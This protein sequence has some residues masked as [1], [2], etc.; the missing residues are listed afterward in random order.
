[1]TTA[2][3]MNLIDG[4]E[5]DT[6]D[7]RDRG[8]MYGDGVFRTCAMRGARIPHWGRQYS[9]LAADCDAINIVCPPAQA[10]ESDIALIA[11]RDADCVV[12]ITV[13][14]GAGA[15][16]YAIPT[17][18][19]PRRIVSTS[20]L[21]VYP[22][23]SY[24]HGV[25]LHLC[26][27]RLA[28][29]PKLAGIKHL[30]RLEQVLARSEWTDSASPE[31]LMRDARGNVICGTMSNLFIIEGNALLT[32]ALDECGVAGVQ[33]DR[34][35]DLARERGI[36]CR[37]AALDLQ[38]VLAADGVFL[39]NSVIGLWPVAQIARERCKQAALTSHIQEWLKA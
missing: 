25:R 11:A 16:G 31:G 5:A 20:A 28:L 7:V 3:P 14:R 1:M 33:R 13:T 36:D 21:P 2:V 17:V 34:V 19:R 6:L 8:I 35:L 38:R 32:P 22:S 29:Q 18:A 26:E 12:R 23:D 9:K 37:I 39:V 30:N 27:I 15:R 24:T 4:I 10:L